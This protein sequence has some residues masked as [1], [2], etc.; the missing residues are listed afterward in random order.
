MVSTTRI[1]IF[2]DFT[3]EKNIYMGKEREGGS[4]GKRKRQQMREKE[5]EI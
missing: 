1:G 2:N 4:I 3:C 5:I